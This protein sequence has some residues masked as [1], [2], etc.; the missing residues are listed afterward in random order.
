MVGHKPAAGAA[1]GCWV[2][3]LVLPLPRRRGDQTRRGAG[4]AAGNP[5]AQQPWGRLDGG[6]PPESESLRLPPP[7]LLASAPSPLLPQPSRPET[8]RAPLRGSFGYPGGGN[9]SAD[10]EAA[11]LA[12]DAPHFLLQLPPPP[13]P[14]GSPHRLLLFLLL[15]CLEASFSAAERSAMSGKFREG[16][17]GAMLPGLCC[18]RPRAALCMRREMDRVCP[19]PEAPREL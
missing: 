15:L 3:A 12:R 2:P 13:P 4:G 8:R 11:A 5:R 19:S 1:L 16:L 18:R 10:W 7:S 14:P 9:P 6:L 17:E